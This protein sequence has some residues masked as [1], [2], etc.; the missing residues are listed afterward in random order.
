MRLLIHA[1]KEDYFKGDSLVDVFH[2]SISIILMITSARAA[3]KREI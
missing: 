2:L 3:R 1:S